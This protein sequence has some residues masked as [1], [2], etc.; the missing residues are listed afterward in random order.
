[1]AVLLSTQLLGFQ[2]RGAVP[3][4]RVAAASVQMQQLAGDG[5][6]ELP[7]PA[8]FLDNHKHNLKDMDEYKAMYKRSVDDPSG[9]WADIANTFH[10]ET[11]FKETVRRSFG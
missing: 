3:R 6:L 7:V 1:M 11:P 4:H 8:A 10:W 5:D 9:F 2:L